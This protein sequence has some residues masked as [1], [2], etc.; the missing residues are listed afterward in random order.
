MGGGGRGE[1]VGAKTL[2]AVAAILPTD[3]SGHKAILLWSGQQE[4]SAAPWATKQP[5]LG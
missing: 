4:S 3:D 2:E 5:Y 1:T